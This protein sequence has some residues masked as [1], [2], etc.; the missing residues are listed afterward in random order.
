[1]SITKA[2]YRAI[3]SIV[4]YMICAHCPFPANA[5]CE[6]SLQSPGRSLL[7]PHLP[8]AESDLI[9]YV[10]AETGLQY[11][12]LFTDPDRRIFIK[13]RGN[14]LKEKFDFAN[15]AAERSKM[16]NSLGFGVKFLGLVKL[17][18][19][20]AVAYEFVQGRIWRGGPIPFRDQLSDRDIERIRLE[21][22]H[23]QSVFEREGIKIDDLQFIVTADGRIILV[24][25]D[26]F[27]SYKHWRLNFLNQIELDRFLNYL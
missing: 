13:S 18:D 12:H 20:L 11:S 26:L 23:L 17:S 27:E 5:Q 6:L 10:P 24:D 3:G 19:G 25:A 16:M 7:L 4:V 15:Q 1:M 21:L 9:P 2:Y 8:I 14:T 22:E